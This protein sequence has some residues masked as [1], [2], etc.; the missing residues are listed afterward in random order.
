MVQMDANKS[1]YSYHKAKIKVGGRHE[2]E[3]TEALGTID[4]Y[5]HTSSFSGHLKGITI[6]AFC[7][8]Q[9]YVLRLSCAH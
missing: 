7:T 1:A 4:E 8:P 3:Y 9:I 5:F 2:I 6:Q